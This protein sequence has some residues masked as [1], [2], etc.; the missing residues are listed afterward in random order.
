MTVTRRARDWVI[1]AM[2]VALPVL[3]LRANVKAPSELNFLDR[4]I[5]RISSP[6]EGAL[7]G[8]A[9]GV[10]GV[11]SHYIYLVHV[12]KDN[13]SLIDENAKLRAQLIEAK[14]E[15]ARG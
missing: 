11:W 5:L 4:V 10:G 12:K 3:F 8:L 9:R 14:Q 1:V 2:L 15:S 7:T 6:I 13:E